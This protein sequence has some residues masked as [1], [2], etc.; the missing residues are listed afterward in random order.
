MSQSRSSG[1]IQ[2]NR[3]EF[4]CACGCTAAGIAARPEGMLAS[5]LAGEATGAA[6]SPAT[7]RG[8]FL[9]PAT[10]S[11]R[12]AGYYSWP[13]STFDA[14][15]HHKAYAAKIAEIGRKLGMRIAMDPA[16]LH[17]KDQVDRFINEVKASK[18]DG[19]LLIPFYKA[20]W[21]SVC[22][23]V[24]EA[25]IPTVIHATLGVLLS[26]H[27]NQLRRTPGVYLI[28]SLD[29]FEAVEGGMRMIR[30]RHRMKHGRIL[31][32]AGSKEGKA[33]VPFLG[34]EIRVLPVKVFADEF[35]RTKPTAEV[36]ALADQYTKTARKAVEPT[37]A[38]VLDAARTCFVCRQLV[39]RE[40]AD[41]IMMDCLGGI[42]RREFPPPCMGFLTLRDEGVPAGCQNDLNATLTMMLVQFLFDRPGFQQNASADTEKNQYWGAHCTS[43]TKLGGPDSPAA[44]YI[45]RSHAEAGVGTV[46][47][48]IWPEG[49]AVTM[50]HYLSGKTPQM[51]V[52]GGKVVTSYGT[53]P[54]GGCRTNVALTIDGVDDVCDVKGM[55]QTI[56][57][58]DY[59]KRLRAFC[60]LMG[61]P[62][63]T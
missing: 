49:Q 42:R 24:K 41:A 47:E 14:E 50:A 39:A 45:L 16:P 33:V 55:H 34:T 20:D 30:T 52:Y 5:V 27:I 26:P 13:G 10:A 44:P 35:E 62:A 46:P 1:G 25:S 43:P 29:N 18:P 40:K 56:F 63:V 2:A 9:Y 23:I 31:S 58:G 36:K 32:L 53:P 7:V 6:T 11:L 37:K 12:K 19:L 57:L 54:A 17:A 48:V 28:S 21:T 60:Q 61:I 22:R 3:R 51:L 8:A 38:D 4:M 15:G 59:A